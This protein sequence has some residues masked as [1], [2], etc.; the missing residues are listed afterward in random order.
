[1]PALT[2]GADPNPIPD[3]TFS[4]GT[5]TTNY[6]TVCRFSYNNLDT[7]TSS[8]KSSGEMDY[9]ISYVINTTNATPGG[10][11]TMNQVLIATSSF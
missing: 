1:M 7:I 11:Y 2:V 9:T 8:T 4:F 3:S 5:P 6:N 10:T